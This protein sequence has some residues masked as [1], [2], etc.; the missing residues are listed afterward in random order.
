MNIF[1][2]RSKPH[3]IERLDVFIEENMVAIGWPGMGDLTGVTK[4]EIR[5][6][7]AK[8][9][10]YED[11]SLATNLGSVNA[12]VNTMQ[13]G[14]IVLLAEGDYVHIGIVGDYEYDESLE[15]EG[16]CHKRSTVWKSTVKKSD[17][18]EEI[19][20]LLRNRTSVTKFP[21]PFNIAG[22]DRYL[23]DN[24]V[25]FRISGGTF[26]DHNTTDLAD[27]ALNV[28]QGYLDDEEHKLMAAIEILRY[29]KP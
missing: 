12:F 27:K 18:N 23:G 1:Q 19:Q 11:Q 24:H 6:R 9:Y 15:N 7:L 22:I 13:A 3:G 26:S 2:I 5:E 4:D 16:M 25:L 14:D 10:G 21:H 20:S 29:L 28:L 8:V 17:L